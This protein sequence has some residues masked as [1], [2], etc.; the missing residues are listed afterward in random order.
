MFYGAEGFR[1][2]KPKDLSNI[3]GINRL[4]ATDQE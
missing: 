2:T 1:T 4:L 3:T